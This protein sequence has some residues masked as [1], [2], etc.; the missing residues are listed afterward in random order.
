MPPKK[1]KV[2]HSEEFSEDFAVDDEFIPS[3]EE[4]FEDLPV[5]PDET[6]EVLD[7]G[8]VDDEEENEEGGVDWEEDDEDASEERPA[9]AVAIPRRLKQEKKVRFYEGPPLQSESDDDIF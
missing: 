2:A 4:D 1:K 8:M 7:E 3:E 6:E 5:E 9:I